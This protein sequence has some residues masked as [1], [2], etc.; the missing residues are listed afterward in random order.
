M[1]SITTNE[2]LVDT[3]NAMKKQEKSGYCTESG[4]YDQI[5]TTTKARTIDAEC[6]RLMVVWLRQLAEFDFSHCT[7]AIAIN[8][9][10]RFVAKEPQILSSHS[11]A[12]E[13]KL[14][15]MTSLYISIKVHEALDVD[16]MTISELSKGQFSPQEIEEMEARILSKL[17]WRVDPPTVM[18]FAEVY[19]QIL[20]PNEQ[21]T[22]I[23]KLIHCQLEHTMEDC[24]F[25]GIDASEIAF[26]ATYNA[27]MVTVDH[28]PH[29][30][31]MQQA[32][33]VNFLPFELKE[34]LMDHMRRSESGLIFSFRP[35]AR[36]IKMQRSGQLSVL[37]TFQR[38]LSPPSIKMSRAA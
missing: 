32:I 36:P 5:T 31:E 4:L 25:L 10:D 14:V 24:Q 35:T 26:T 18:D 23:K 6:R 27:I 9:L 37:S 2:D 22:T 19:L 21:K 34:M 38:P 15:A 33:N 12:Y 8:M 16:P 11:A 29:L 20:L 28:F 17:D 13:F 3:I 7:I 30:E 1:N